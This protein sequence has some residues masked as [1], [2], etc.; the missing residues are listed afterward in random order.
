MS[1]RPPAPPDAASSPSAPSGAGDAKAIVLPVGSAEASVSEIPTREE[2]PTVV[3]AR[4]EVHL[5]VAEAEASG[6]KAWSS[7]VFFEAA[8]LQETALEQE[9]AAAR[10]YAKSLT[11]DPTF[12][13]TAWRLRQQLSRQGFWENLIRVIEAEA[14]FASNTRS[15][16]RSD[17]L[18]EKALHQWHR[19]PRP[20]LPRDSFTEAVQA[21]PRNRAALMGSLLHALGGGHLTEVER[22]FEGL[23][24]SATSATDTAAWTAALATWLLTSQAANS[25]PLARA[26]RAVDVLLRALAS[27]VREP[28]LLAALDRFSLAAGDERLRLAALQAWDDAAPAARSAHMDAARLVALRERARRLAAQGDLVGAAQALDRALLLE[29][30]HPVVAADRLDLAVL[31]GRV[32]VFDAWPGFNDDPAVQAELLFRRA[33][34]AVRQGAWGEAMGALG[35]VSPHADLDDLCFAERLRTLAGLQDAHGMAQAYEAHADGLLARVPAHDNEKKALHEVAHQYVRAGVLWEAEL[36]DS[37]RAETLY[38]QA[39]AMVPSYRPALEG[40]ASVFTREGRWE[41]LVDLVASDAA[42][43]SNSTRASALRESLVLLNRDLLF[44]W[45]AAMA[46]QTALLRDHEDARGLFR[47]LDLAALLSQKDPSAL[48]DALAAVSRLRQNARTGTGRAALSLLGA[49]LVMGTSRDAEVDA[50]LDRALA[51]DPLSLSAAFIERRS[52]GEPTRVRMALQKE[53]DAHARAAATADAAAVDRVRA[54]RFRQAF[55]SLEAG[56]AADAL[57]ALE[58]LVRA[59]DVFAFAWQVDIVRRLRDPA[60]LRR[61]LLTPHAGPEDAWSQAQAAHERAELTLLLAQCWE[62]LGRRSDAAETFAQAAAL[63]EQDA[64]GDFAVRSHL[65]CLRSAA[66]ETNI[67]VTVASL[68][69]LS[70][71]FSGDLAASFAQEAQHILLATGG[72]ISPAAVVPGDV[73]LSWLAAARGDDGRRFWACLQQVAEESEPSAARAALWLHLALDAAING[74]GDAEHAFASSYETVA[75]PA[76]EVAVADLPGMTVPVAFVEQLSSARLARLTDAARAGDEASAALASLVALESA[77]AAETDGRLGAAAA[78]YALVLELR[79]DSLE[80][81]EGLRRLAQLAGARAHEACLLERIGDS[82]TSATAAAAHYAEAALLAEADGENDVAVRL[83]YK[84]LTRA[85]SDDEAFERLLALQRS[86]EAW[87]HV[88]N[89]LGF[90][91]T[92]LGHNPKRCLPLWLE[93]ARLRYAHLNKVE[94]ALL[95]WR[96]ALAVDEDLFEAQWRLAQAAREQG[97]IPAARARFLFASR[98]RCDEPVM[99]VECLIELAE[100]CRGQGDSAAARAAL[101]RVPEVLEHVTEPAL[102]RLVPL[103]VALGLAPLAELALRKI[104]D[105]HAGSTRAGFLLQ[106]ARVLRDANQWDSA[107]RAA[108][109]AIAADPYGDAIIDFLDFPASVRESAPFDVAQALNEVL[110]DVCGEGMFV[111]PKVALLDAYANVAGQTWRQNVVAQLLFLLGQGNARGVAHTISGSID[112]DTL[113]ALGAHEELP[114]VVSSIQ[115]SWPVLAP[116]VHKVWSSA[117]NAPAG[118]RSQR[119]QAAEEPRLDWFLAAA[120]T[121]GLDDVAT[122]ATPAETPVAILSTPTNAVAL[123]PSVLGGDAG[124]R[125]RAARALALLKLGVPFLLASTDVQPTVPWAVAA[126][127]VVASGGVAAG[128]TELEQKLAKAISKKA[129]K[130]A[131]LGNLSLATPSDVTQWLAQCQ[132]AAIRFAL[133]VAGDLPE[134]TYALVGSRK[135]ENVQADDNARALIAFA[136]SQAHQDLRQRLGLQNGGPRG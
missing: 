4:D 120:R 111:L 96:R 112:T 94:A 31:A 136:L 6:D 5:L 59:G 82:L 48:S 119:M 115:A 77:H 74:Y 37:E 8:Y 24:E 123:A 63:A 130:A 22:A 54:L 26:S 80:A 109:H 29:P 103:C 66:A 50:L 133:A 110:A 7:R 15:Q 75:T 57:S 95:D 21:D 61:L 20:E 10:T 34:M 44:D 81:L 107:A 55:V 121:L 126:L 35:Q 23:L 16:D 19:S 3:L 128:D 30:E 88:E 98:C 70:D 67:A 83:F 92:Q 40:L 104:A 47:W 76:V 90:K 62:S 105:Q 49:R 85:P 46:A 71:L 42:A 1:S 84:V 39:L 87:P 100:V 106:A 131:S 53:L 125:F 134:A 132:R 118:V 127:R 13:P 25:D 52:R 86:A 93:R 17:L 135:L 32:N 116:A 91:L 14:R 114:A 68:Q 33:D 56:Q 28:T 117:T 12:Q 102:Q 89:L 99:L 51:D 113:F 60:L 64:S 65:G 41:S 18:L 38:S 78:T 43:A 2:S 124:S 72:A 69:A 58:P 129:I 9:K 11:T 36:A 45:Q 73:S 101:N 27:G 108:G 79:P 122:F 97:A